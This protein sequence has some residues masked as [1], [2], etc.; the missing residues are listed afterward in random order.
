[1]LFLLCPRPY[2]PFAHNAFVPRASL[3]VT[4]TYMQK[5]PF[6]YH[7]R[8]AD[9]WLECS[10]LVPYRLSGKVEIPEISWWYSVRTTTTDAVKT[11]VDMSLFF[12]LRPGP[13]AIGT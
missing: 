4:C 5:S 6:S 7:A 11:V 3:L 9:S 2:A 1:M 8:A 10:A 13:P 12:P